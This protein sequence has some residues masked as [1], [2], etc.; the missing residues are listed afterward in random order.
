MKKRTLLIGLFVCITLVLGFSVALG[1]VDSPVSSMG[2]YVVNES[3]LDC[4]AL[5]TVDFAATP[6]IREEAC[7]VCHYGNHQTM[8]VETPYGW[9]RTADSPNADADI[10][11]SSIHSNLKNTAGG[12]ARCHVTASCSACHA[13]VP[14]GQHGSTDVLPVTV[15]TTTG[16]FFASIKNETFF[17]GT[18]HDTLPGINRYR[19]DGQELC[20]NCHNTDSS[21]HDPADLAQQHWADE[22][23]FEGELDVNCSNCHDNVL[24]YEH[25]NRGLDCMTCHGGGVRDEVNYAIENNL[26]NCDACHA[27][28]HDD[29]DDA[30]I[31]AFMPDA[32]V[33]CSDCHS[34]NLVIE[35][36]KFGWDCG[37]CHNSADGRIVSAISGG[38]SN[39]SACHDTIHRIRNKKMPG[40]SK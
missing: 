33:S 4:H 32:I 40:S 16:G 30:H 18:C 35:H 22:F 8:T 36:D 2:G 5:E 14:H 38:D 19:F 29:L 25:E 26:R 3:C 39:C 34:N 21:G 27:P 37:T 1:T 24:T 12:C 31:S 7:R 15:W 6:V 11:H 28:I 13:E 10:L 20:I 17:C 9:F 23:M